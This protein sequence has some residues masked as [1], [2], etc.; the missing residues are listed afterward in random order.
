[1]SRTA[2]PTSSVRPRSSVRVPPGLVLLLALTAATPLAAQSWTGELAL[3]IEVENE[4][5]QPVPGARVLVGYAETDAFDGPEAVVTGDDGRTVIYGLAEGLWRVQVERESYSRYLAVVRLERRGKKVEITAGPLRDASAPP[6]TV[7]Y[8]KSA[9][10]RLSPDAPQTT[11]RGAE[12]DDRADRRDRADD[13][14]SARERR[15]AEREEQERADA[16]ARGERAAP[17]PEASPG[18]AVPPEPE[19]EET[20]AV[21]PPAREVPPD[22]KR[23]PAPPPEMEPVRPPQPEPATPEAVTEQMPEPAPPAATTLP[24]S[25]IRTGASGSCVDCKPGES[26]VSARVASGSRA[27]GSAAGCPPTLE[28]QVREA[29]AVLAAAPGPQAGTYAGPLTDDGRLLPWATPAAQ[30]RAETLLAPALDPSSACR[31]ALVVLPPSARFAGYRYQAAD[32]Q[33]GGD[34][35]AGRDCP[36]GDALWGGHPQ[37]EKTDA[38]T[39]L[40][41]VFENRSERWDRRAEMTVYFQAGR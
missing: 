38:G 37:V 10:Q 14:R 17:R 22:V 24:P 18:R 30:A 13:R 9:G 23:R 34:C 16:R 19:P 40:Y 3:G 28:A 36:I 15:R 7:S 21:Q 32:A 27:P 26:A 41:S 5:G 6:L 20:P 1:M 4:A 25:P 11:E 2:V 29:I 12:R 33:A 31:V 35:L 8:Q 39:F